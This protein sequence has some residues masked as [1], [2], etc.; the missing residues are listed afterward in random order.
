MYFIRFALENN[1][2]FVLMLMHEITSTTENSGSKTQSIVQKP[3]SASSEDTSS[4]FTSL[5]H[6]LLVPEIRTTLDV[7]GIENEE[8]VSRDDSTLLMLMLCA[9][10][11]CVITLEK[12]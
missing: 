3:S 4:G 11:S 10:T 1:R 2:D 9:L 12:K 5:M 8:S 7:R 6:A